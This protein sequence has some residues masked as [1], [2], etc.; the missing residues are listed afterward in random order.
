MRHGILQRRLGHRTSTHA[1]A[2]T[3]PAAAASHG[4]SSRRR[5]LPAA[6]L[7]GLLGAE[8][9]IV[10]LAAGKASLLA[11]PKRVALTAWRAGPLHGLLADLPY[12]RTA[13]KVAFLVL[14]LAM[15]ACYLLVLRRVRTLPSRWVLGAIVVAHLIVLVGPPLILTDVFNY[16]DYARVGVVHHLNP[17]LHPPHAARHDSIYRYT[18]WHF[19]STPYGPLFT[20]ATYPLARLNISLG[21][22]ILKVSTALAS[23]GCV[24]LV[25]AC[26]RRLGRPAL[27]CAAA[28]GLNPLLV[29]YGVGGVHNDFYMMVLVLAGLYWLLAERHALGGAALVASAA[30]KLA[31]APLVPFLL[32]RAER[33]VRALVGALIAAIAVVV[34]AI[35]AFGARAPGVSDQANT[36]TR[37]SLPDDIASI[38]G[39]PVS[40]RC[41]GHFYPC[42]NG[43]I[44]FLATASLALAIGFL[45]W[46]AWRGADPIACAGWAAVALLVTL[47]SVMPWYLLWVLPLAVLSRS[48]PLQITAGVLGVLLV[49]ASQPTA[50][51]LVYG[52]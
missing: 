30:V 10:L 4:H 28:V 8:F 32:I 9:G 11:P 41:A 49:L 46:R 52:A 13:L 27:L 50:H 31:S 47:T 33:R 34:V 48:R 36:V 24:A 7:L 20:L 6:G 3:S 37:F 17:Y 51:L 42:V 29:V 40:T 39:V 14:V 15:G 1:P 16:L 45:L 44:S 2:P 12:D 25:A 38:F 19:Q 18:S 26:A 23:L 5:A 21:L 35:A 22:W 43:T